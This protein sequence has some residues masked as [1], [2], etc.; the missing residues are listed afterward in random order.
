VY[1]HA[2][3]FLAKKIASAGMSDGDALALIDS[4]INH[5]EA[6]HKPNKLMDIRDIYLRLIISAQ[7]ANMK[8]NVIG[9]FIGGIENLRP[10]LCDFDPKRT[11]KKFE[12]ADQLLLEIEE[13]LQLKGKIRK[14][15]NSLWPKF[16]RTVVEGASF[17]SKF[18]D[19]REFIE[20]ANWFYEDERSM[21]VLPLLLSEDVYGIGY[22]LACDF[23]KELGFVNYGK[24]DVHITDIFIGV[25]L[26]PKGTSLY[27]IQKIIYQIAKANSNSEKII[28][29]YNADKLFYLI[30]SG[31]LYKD[32]SLINIGKCKK[33]FINEFNEMHNQSFDKFQ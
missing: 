3:S 26:C 1:D 17:L 30:G 33:E 18:S 21:P 28:T 23:L 25:G 16:C 11:S 4:H 20:W 12:N 9:G 19:G 31:D 32:K 27:N 6:N 15:A 14:A 29:P 13:I 5:F 2:L 24:P 8:K 22:A 10:I 7:N